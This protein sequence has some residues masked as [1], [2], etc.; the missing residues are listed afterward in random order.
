MIK[1]PARYDPKT[2]PTT[3]I[4]TTIMPIK[5]M[6]NS[7]VYSSLWLRLIPMMIREAEKIANMA[8]I[9]VASR[10]IPPRLIPVNPKRGFQ[11]DDCDTGWGR[12]SIER[13]SSKFP[14]PVIFFVQV[15]AVEPSSLRLAEF[16]PT[17][18][19]LST[20]E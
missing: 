11:P 19:I 14:V 4:P 18:E 20:R 9:S 7:P 6:K 15:E 1:K 17:E 10:V 2:I 16:A 3:K 12:T 13:I 5:D 8:R